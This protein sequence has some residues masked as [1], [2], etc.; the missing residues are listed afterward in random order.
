MQGFSRNNATRQLAINTGHSLEDKT[1]K[2]IFFLFR[3][4]NMTTTTA[5]TKK[6]N[7][8]GDSVSNNIFETMTTNN[9][10]TKPD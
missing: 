7:R 5:K 3:F 2:K 10:K 1:I 9:N 8:N 6:S 4:D